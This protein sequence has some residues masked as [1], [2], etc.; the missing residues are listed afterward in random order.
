METALASASR[1]LFVPALMWLLGPLTLHAQQLASQQ[2]GRPEHADVAPL[3]PLL[4]APVSLSGPGRGASFN[5]PANQSMLIETNELICFLE[6]HDSDDVCRKHYRFRTFHKVSG[7]EVGGEG[8]VCE[9]YYSIS[10]PPGQG[11]RV[12]DRGSVLYIDAGFCK[13]R[14]SLG[15]WLYY[16]PAIATMSIGSRAEYEQRIQARKTDGPR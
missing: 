16:D 3:I 15:R 6:L 7:Y 11:I 8:H 10:K 1:R 5:V 13:I 9:K 2:L 12:M 4:N 14:W